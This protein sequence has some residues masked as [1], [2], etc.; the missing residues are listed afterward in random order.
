MKAPRK[1][2]TASPPTSADRATIAALLD[3]AEQQRAAVNEQPDVIA[4]RAA[5]DRARA[6]SDEA[7]RH[8]HTV[9]DRH[10]PRDEAIVRHIKAMHPSVLVLGDE[11]HQWIARCVVTGLPIFAGDNVIMQGSYDNANL[12]YVLADFVTVTGMTP[13]ITQAQKE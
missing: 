9:F 11:P 3:N 10:Y 4:A 1:T 5:S 2:V 6:A 13:A 8:F 7:A 12:T